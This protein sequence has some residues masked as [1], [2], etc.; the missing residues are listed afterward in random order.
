MKV[1]FV[2]KHKKEVQI[3]INLWIYYELQKVVSLLL[4]QNWVQKIARY[5]HSCPFGIGPPP[6]HLVF[7]IEILPLMCFF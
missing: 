4:A 6:P 2:N 5:I 3:Q 7:L 1:K